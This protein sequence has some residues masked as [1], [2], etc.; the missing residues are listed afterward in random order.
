MYPRDGKLISFLCLVI[1][2]RFLFFFFWKLWETGWN[3]FDTVSSHRLWTPSDKPYLS[4]SVRTNFF[5]KVNSLFFS[6]VP[7]SICFFFFHPTLS[8]PWRLR[9]HVYLEIEPEHL[10]YREVED[11]AQA[12]VGEECLAA[13]AGCATPP[14]APA[15]ARGGAIVSLWGE[16]LPIRCEL[17]SLEG[18]GQLRRRELDAGGADLRRRDLS[19]GRSCRCHEAARRAEE[20]TCSYWHPRSMRKL[21]WPTMPSMPSSCSPCA[22]TK[23]AM[24]L[25]PWLSSSRGSTSSVR[26]GD[27]DRV[28]SVE[29]QWWRPRW[30]WRGLRRSLSRD[31]R[32]VV[33]EVEEQLRLMVQSSIYWPDVFALR[34]DL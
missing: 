7:Y 30:W 26:G 27:G 6:A 29:Q 28:S 13:R 3:N 23:A 9:V 20:T 21:A 8:S 14:R 11:C 25:S 12:V 18:R 33:D 19:V 2:G 22:A 17:G 4:F 31:P 10:R 16:E 1:T 32:S 15:P 5:L 34:C 24:S